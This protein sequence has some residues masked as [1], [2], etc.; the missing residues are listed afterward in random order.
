MRVAIF[1]AASAL[2]LA[3]SPS[4]A[5]P[6]CMTQAEARAKFPTQ[7][8]WWH[9]ANRCWDATP[10]RR[11]LA[12]RIEARKQVDAEPEVKATRAAPEEKKPEEKKPAV[13]NERRWRDAMSRM[14]PE[15]FA[16]SVGS[17]RAEASADPSAT[18][19]VP[20]INFFERWVDIAQSVPPIAG[21]A[22]PANF[23]A[24]ARAA[25]PLVTPTRVMLGLLVLILSFG[26][27]ELLRRP[28]RRAD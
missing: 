21:K 19:A 8:L 10:G 14:R 17:A 13:S 6:A 20:R 16:G 12:K 9:G 15:D 5:S 2:A 3:S 23:A 11:Q 28:N 18:P 22:A 26:L 7:H 25:E 27:F 1:L 4:I 24:D